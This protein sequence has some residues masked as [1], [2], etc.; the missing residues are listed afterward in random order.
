MQLILKL[1]TLFEKDNIGNVALDE[2]KIILSEIDR[3]EIS[4]KYLDFY[5][6]YLK[7]EEDDF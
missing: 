4:E 1:N 6:Y 5:D 2:I 3:E 7:K